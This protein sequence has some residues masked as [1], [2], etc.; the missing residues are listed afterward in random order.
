[1]NKKTPAFVQNQ[2]TLHYILMKKRILTGIKPTGLPHIGNYFGAIKPAL[3][4]PKETQRYIFIAD[5]HALTTIQNNNDIRQHSYEVAAAWLAL[6][7]DPNQT[8]FYKQSD[9][10][11][12]F[13]LMWILSCVTPKG[14]LNRAHAYKAAT[15][16]NKLANKDLDHNINAGI[17]N[18]PVLMAADILLFQATHIPVGSDQKQHIE[19]A[20]DIAESLNHVC[21][22]SLAIPEPIVTKTESAV[23]GIDG[24]K[25]SKSYNNTLPIF[26]AEKALRKRCMQIVT[27]STPQ[28]APKNP[29]TC[30]IFSLH[31]LFL[32]DEEQ[33]ALRARYQAGNIGY[34][35]LKQE[36][37]ETILSTFK[38]ARNQYDT[39]IENT[40][41]IDN[42][43][44]K[45]AEQ[46]RHNAI[47]SLKAIKQKI[48]L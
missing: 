30:N 26:S 4:Y 28:E 48:S 7:L 17:F 6:G 37:Y 31:S 35:T 38:N 24:Q 13:E 42:I 43:L 14:L 47:N 36:L 23:P 21:G 8:I 19:I 18:Y 1:L 25:M 29:D 11:E 16:T 34:G 41:E 44:K 5:Y 39:L 32:S 40:H 10:P 20:R 22:T 45:G 27:D 46:A 12:I 33:T 3:A 9:I 15:N 2:L